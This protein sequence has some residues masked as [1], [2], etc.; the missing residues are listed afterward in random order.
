M[1]HIFKGKEQCHYSYVSNA[2]SSHHI[3]QFYFIIISDIICS[4]VSIS[5]HRT[6]GFEL[7]VL[8]HLVLMPLFPSF[9]PSPLV[10]LFPPLC[11][12]RDGLILLED[13]AQSSLIWL[14]MSPLFAGGRTRW[15][16]KVLPSKRNYSMILSF[17]DFLYA[18]KHVSHL[19]DARTNYKIFCCIVSGFCKE[20]FFL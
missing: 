16:L 15:P 6:E 13:R 8:V 2:K 17:K 14:K 4:L 10:A 3:L 11:I 9:S 20:T 1:I 7:N 19:S 12:K 5:L 18:N